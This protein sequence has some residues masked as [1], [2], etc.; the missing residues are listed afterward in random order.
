MNIGKTPKISNYGLLTTLLYTSNCNRKE[1]V[2]AFEGAIETAGVVINWLKKNL[3]L[4]K[5]FSELKSLFESVDSSGG[6]I[7]VPAFSGLYSPYW[8]DTA[9]GAIFG[10]SMQTQKGHIVRASYDA[11]SLRTTEVIESLE[12]SSNST[13]NTLK[14]DGG[15]TISDNF[16]QT[17]SNILNKNVTKQNETEI[18]IIGSAIVAGLEKDV[19]LWESKEEV[20]KLLKFEKIFKN[21]MSDEERNLLREKW[22]KA[23]DRAKKWHD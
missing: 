1:A 20:A 22:N 16:L 6:I 15:L 19:K 21:E 2:Y 10:L 11:I 14:V 13:V 17:Q 12:K 5:E 23:I 4:F 9:T 8:D 3:E 7:F 18:T